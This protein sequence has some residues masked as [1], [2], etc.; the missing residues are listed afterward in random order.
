MDPGISTAL[1]ETFRRLDR[2]KGLDQPEA[3]VSTAT[4]S[5]LTVDSATASWGSATPSEHVSTTDKAELIR[6]LERMLKKTPSAG[7]FDTW[8]EQV[9]AGIFGT[10]TDADDNELHAST[11]MPPEAGS[12]ASLAPVPAGRDQSTAP[13]PMSTRLY[14]PL[15]GFVDIEPS[16]V[17]DR[18]HG[19][20]EHW[21]RETLLFLGVSPLAAEHL[22]MLDPFADQDRE[23]KLRFDSPRYD[24]KLDYRLA[25]SM[26]ARNMS[27]TNMLVHSLLKPFL[28]V[29]VWKGSIFFAVVMR[30]AKT[31]GFRAKSRGLSH[32]A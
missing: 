10:P 16:L 25:G 30:H 23:S 13:A 6:N 31:I 14:N 15:D 5:S 26:I 12:D 2:L 21:R 32:S 8:V 11:V 3:N 4:S 27:N 17:R 22:L 28:E 29:G 9:K 19:R 20:L 1:T 18:A 7:E 24:L